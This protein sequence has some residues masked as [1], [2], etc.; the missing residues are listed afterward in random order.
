MSTVIPRSDFARDILSVYAVITWAS[1][2]IA[3]VVFVALGGILVRF[4][5][6]PGAPLPAQTRGHT[7]LE[8]AWT[9][10]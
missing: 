5:D 10:A 4:R 8:L 2:G 1:V 3:L 6:R 7:L 9:V